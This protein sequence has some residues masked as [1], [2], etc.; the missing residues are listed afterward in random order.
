MTAPTS[1]RGGTLAFVGPAALFAVAALV[2]AGLL[3]AGTEATRG[4][5]YLLTGAIALAVLLAG[6]GWLLDR[7]RLKHLAE[8]TGD[9]DD[10]L[11]EARRAASER[12]RERDEARQSADQRGQELEREQHLRGRV[13]RARRAEREWSQELRGQLMAMHRERG[14]L[15]RTDD[16]RELV[17]RTA[18]ELREAEKGILLAREDADGDGLLDLVAHQGFENDPADSAVAQRFSREVIEHDMAVREDDPRQLEGPTGADEEIRNLVAIPIYIHDRFSG[19]VVCVNRE[20][21][22]AEFDDQVLVSLGDHAGAVLDS[23]RLQ[24]ELRS[25]YLA[26]V[27]MLGEALEAKDP[28]LRGHSDEVSRHVSAVADRIGI[29]ADQ[30][31]RLVFGS[32]LHDVGKIGISERILLKPGPL[33]REERAV[34]ELHPRIGYHLIQHVPALKGM[35]PA[36]LHHH[37]RFDGGGYP[38]GLVGEQ[39][40][41]EARIVC[42]AD[43]F[44]AMTA[45][46]PYRSSVSTSDACEEL[47][48]CAGTQFDPEVVRLFVEE[49]RMGRREPA[50]APTPS[51]LDDPEIAVRRNGD[52]AV[53][54]A[55]SFAITDNLTL[56][57][58]YRHL[59]EMAGNEAERA[60]VQDSTFSALALEMVDIAEL[61]RREGYAAGDDS[62]VGVARVLERVAARAG[63]TAARLGGRRLALILPRSGEEETAGLIDELIQELERGPT[64]RIARATWS[65]GERGHE[66]VDRAR[67]GLRAGAPAP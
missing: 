22:F 65:P 24:G 16:V 40:P 53:L 49:V 11:E 62:I 36:I 41:L 34:C 28:L 45:E 47:E 67:A 23:S 6:A 35:A 42:V 61:N 12:E 26:T 27:R 63:G 48:R 9:V 17:L 29:P 21:G 56:L 50:P 52:E 33:T 18:V 8:Q 1:R 39:I 15:G 20:G 60:S 44:S 3:V 32:L 57:Y 31:E 59:L 13:E 4:L 2:I 30:R 64:V 38:S 54:G 51:L 43:S 25:S 10:Q 14:A 58:S 37:E 66:V 55:S 46:R 19:A 5:S 7:R